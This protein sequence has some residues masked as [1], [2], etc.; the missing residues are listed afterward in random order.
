MVWEIDSMERPMRNRYI[1]YNEIPPL[2]KEYLLTVAEKRD[3]M[4]IPIEDINSYLDGLHEYYKSL[5]KA[6]FSES[7]IMALLSE[8]ETY[9]DWI[10]PS[11]PNK[12]DPIP[13]DD[14][15]DE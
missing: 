8:K 6:G 3:I 2:M 12:I 1:V 15:E 5:K 10:L 13:Y 14:D 9:P 4:E 11:I 7:W